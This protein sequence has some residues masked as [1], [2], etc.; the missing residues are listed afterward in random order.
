[1]CLLALKGL[2]SFLL[3][4]CDLRVSVTL[5]ANVSPLH[6][7]H[8]SDPGELAVPFGQMVQS[9]LPDVLR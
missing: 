1:M 2:N 9:V 7:L 5:V 6:G 3:K 4:H 8:F